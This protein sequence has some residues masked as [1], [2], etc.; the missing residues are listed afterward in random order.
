LDQDRGFFGVLR[1]IQTDQ[2]RSMYHGLIV[3][4]AQWRDPV[5][6]RLPH[7]YYSPR[8]PLGRLLTRAPDDAALGVVGLG[9]GGLAALCRPGQ[10]MAFYEIDRLVDRMARD[11]FTFLEDSA[12]RPD[13]VFGDGRL[14]LAERADHSLDL[15]VVDAFSGDA[16]PIHLATTEAVA[17]YMRKLA[18]GG[19]LAFHISNRYVDLAPVLAAA[20]ERLGLAAA[21]IRYRPDDAARREGAFPSTVA[22][23]SPD[24]AVIERL[25]REEAGWRHL[26]PARGVPWT[27]DHADL[28]RVLRW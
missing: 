9:T 25:V 6:R 3:H 5:R 23:L 16:I 26:D 8:A 19:V 24:P 12:C 27:D 13:V 21:M 4:G 14:S 2:L 18:A 15:L 7:G 10:S 17:L 22:A 11:H 1:V 28:W 20:A